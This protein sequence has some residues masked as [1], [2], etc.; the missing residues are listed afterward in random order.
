MLEHLHDP[1]NTLDR[2]W[3]ILKPGGRLG[4]MTQLVIDRDRFAN[5]HYT[6]DPTHVGFFSV[7]TLEWLARHW[8]AQIVHADNGVCLFRKREE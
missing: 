3:S 2:L 8:S 7:R 1:R 4:V 5:W 6:A